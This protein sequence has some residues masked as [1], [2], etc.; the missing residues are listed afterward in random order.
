[1]PFLK[2][3]CDAG[4]TRDYEF[5]YTVSYNSTGK[6]TRGKKEKPTREAQR[7]VNL[8][9]V[10]KALARILNANF[11]RRD[12]Y[13]TYTYRKESRPVNS[14][15]MKKQIRKL[16]DRLRAIQKREGRELKYVWVAE[17]GKKGAAHIHMVVNHIDIGRVRD[18]WEHG[19]LDVTPLDPSGQYR[20]LADYMIKYAE[21][22]EDA[23]GSTVGKRYNP[24]R[25]LKRPK[26]KTKIITG[27]KKIP[28]DIKVPKGWYL[29]QD[30]VQSGIHEFT[31]FR[32]LSYSL[33]RLEERGG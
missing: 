4:K 10:K 32:Y 11:G 16:L 13:I 29:D 8:R 23:A 3:Q 19:F 22:T 30:S 1:M 5:Y 17:V 24:S 25:N 7:A 26:P 20:K 21:K 6:R 31:G 14:E 27:R 9:K 33:I 28:E 2:S 15:E 12:F 18:A